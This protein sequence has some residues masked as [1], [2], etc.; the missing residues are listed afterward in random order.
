MP[1]TQIA[2]N[3]TGVKIKRMKRTIIIALVVGL[4]FT[5]A[6]KRT[7]YSK[8]KTE[9]P[10]VQASIKET[11]IISLTVSAA[12]SLKGPMEEIKQLYA[13]ENQKV[14]INYNFGSS[15]SL[16]QQIE[17]GADVDLFIPAATKQMNA[18]Q[19]K[20]LIIDNTKKSLLGNKLVLVIP[21]DSQTTITDFKGLANDEFKKIALGEPKSVPAGQ[22]AEEVFTKLNI[23]ES[24]KLK[25]VYGKDVK[26]VL[27]W[28]ESGNADAGIVYE[29]DA[30]SSDKVKTIAAA[31]AGSH[32]PIIYPAAI[33]K[34]SR[35]ADVAKEFLT[36][37]SGD[38]AKVVF[39]KY[40]FDFI[41]K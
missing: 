38:K 30:K 3:L 40:G 28:V 35:N 39:E 24:I 37:L 5:V 34:T 8:S 29:S 21:K 19:D 27:T 9:V 25:A 26:E 14:I 16:Q 23:L 2:E 7:T 31:P 33:V 17:Q 6:C 12:A 20:E 10:P 36:F 4:I 41:A 11:K 13:K 18:L 32:T 1:N 15:G 22:Y